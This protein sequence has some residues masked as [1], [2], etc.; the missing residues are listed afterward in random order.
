MLVFIS[1]FVPRECGIATF[2]RDLFDSINA[3][4]GI[5]AMSDRKYRYDERVIGEIK[6]DRI[7][8]Y[9]KIAQKL[10]NDDDAKLIHI[11]HEFGIFGGEYG[12]YILHFLNGLNK[13]TLSTLIS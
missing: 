8:D 5:V 6:E 9:I 10:N 1:T 3:G 13:S 11:Q 2:T 7:N 4:K 12:E